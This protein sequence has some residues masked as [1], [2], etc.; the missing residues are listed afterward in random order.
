[1][2]IRFNRDVE[3]QIIET[4][5]DALDEVTSACFETFKAG[6]VHDVEIMDWDSVKSDICTIQF[7][8]GSCA[9]GVSTKWFDEV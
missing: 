6:E 7:G 8:D 9:Y 5:D 3:L 4:F 1:M 2:K